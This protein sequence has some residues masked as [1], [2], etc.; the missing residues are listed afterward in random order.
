MPWDRRGLIDF[1]RTPKRPFG[2]FIPI[3]I[4]MQTVSEDFRLNSS[5]GEVNRDG[6]PAVE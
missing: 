6:L 5:T 3:F 1:F 2:M 4:F